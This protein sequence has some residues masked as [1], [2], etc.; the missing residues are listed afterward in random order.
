MNRTILLLI[1]LVFGV[2]VY[3][4]A[5]RGILV[6]PLIIPLAV[7]VALYYVVTSLVTR[8]MI[9]KA[10]GEG[11]FFYLKASLIS[12]DGTSITPGAMAVTDNEIVFYVRRSAKGGVRPMWSCFVQAL[13]GYTIK[14]VDD[15]HP[16]IVLSLAGEESEVKFASRS[17][18]GE[19]AAFRKALGWP[20]E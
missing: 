9:E 10:R 7:L 5:F 12:R 6:W 1:L 2:F 18:A 8:K 17:I 14:K 3:F 19:E 16:G 13:D 20:E 15:R 11:S 4:I